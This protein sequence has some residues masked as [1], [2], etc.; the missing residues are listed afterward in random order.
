[1]M[2]GL[3][4]CCMHVGSS[5]LTRDRTWVPCFGSV[6]FLATGPPGK[7]LD[8]GFLRVVLTSLSLSPQIQY[9]YVCWEGKKGAIELCFTV[10]YL[11][12]CVRLLFFQLRVL[13]WEYFVF[14]CKSA[15][16]RILP[17]PQQRGNV[18]FFFSL[19]LGLSVPSLLLL[20]LSC[21]SRVRLCATL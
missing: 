1:M 8:W 15:L 16:V 20:L 6:E 7:S 2:C 4:G 21:F 3:P 17:S 9:L 18:S 11:K 10:T 13:S 12:S 14:Y 19:S 5:S